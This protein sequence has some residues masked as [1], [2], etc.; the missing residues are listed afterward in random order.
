[1]L[2]CAVQAVV[3]A[4]LKTFS[5]DSTVTLPAQTHWK[6]RDL[7][8]YMESESQFYQLINSARDQSDHETTETKVLLLGLPIMNS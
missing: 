5:L 3:R 7:H 2:C 8:F 6:L 4:L 1:V